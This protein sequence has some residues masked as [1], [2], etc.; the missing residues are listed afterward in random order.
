MTKAPETVT[1]IC[2]SPKEFWLF[3]SHGKTDT[4]A[5]VQSFDSQDALLQALSTKLSFMD[6][7]DDNQN[8]RYNSFEAYRYYPGST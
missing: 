1:V 6:L 2:R 4:K 5:Y 7:G 8:L 3:D